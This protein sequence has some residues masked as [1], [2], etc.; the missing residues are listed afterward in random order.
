MTGWS[1]GP[2]LLVHILIATML[3]ALFFPIFYQWTGALLYA[4]FFSVGVLCVYGM[5]ALLLFG[6]R[7]R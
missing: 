5:I 2:S 6:R 1:K 3:N 7:R 4:F